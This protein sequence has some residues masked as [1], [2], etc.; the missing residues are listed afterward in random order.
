MSYS[1]EWI[2]QY[3]K[4]WHYKITFRSRRLPDNFVCGSAV[5]LLG[6]RIFWIWK[7]ANSNYKWNLNY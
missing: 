6:V 5:K 1:K 2:K 7:I 4:T 3:N